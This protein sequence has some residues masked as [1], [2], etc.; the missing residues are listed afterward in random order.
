MK[1]WWYLA[2][3]GGLVSWALLAASVLW[4]LL[5][6]T[7]LFR[8]K[9]RPAWT[10]DLHRF[11]GGSAVIFT[12]I[13]V[14]GLVAD[15]YVHFGPAEILIPLASRW[16]P[17]AVAWGVLALYLLLGIEVTSLGMKK[18]SN[19]AWRRVHRTSVVLFAFAT[20]HGITAGTDV[21]GAQARVAAIVVSGLVLFLWLLRVLTGKGHP[22][23]RTPHNVPQRIRKQPLT[24]EAR[25]IAS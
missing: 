8:N 22:R 6:A 17:I 2:R 13:H 3:A 1:L 9:P 20:V 24:P 5:L 23:R 14:A 25:P 10:L 18:L 7:R 4:G 21:R 11:L 16:H 19:R 15:T 12:G